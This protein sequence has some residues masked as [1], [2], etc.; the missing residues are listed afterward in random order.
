VRRL[1]ISLIV[2][3]LTFTASGLLG[4]IVPEPCTPYELAG[5][6]QDDGQCAPTCMTCGCCAR[7]LVPGILA[8][9]SSPEQTVSLIEAVLQR[10]PE[11]D[12]HPILHVPKR[13]P[14]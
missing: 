2:A 1:A 10:V 4:L 8:A 13:L 11:T 7:P 9:A 12:P 14:A 6:G 5:S 3:S